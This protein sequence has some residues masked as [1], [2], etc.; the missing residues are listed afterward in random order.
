MK[1]LLAS[2]LFLAAVSSVNAQKTS[3]PFPFGKWR[4]VFTFR[5]GVEVPVNFEIAGKTISDA[6]VFFLNAAERFDGGR[7]IKRNDSLF[8]SLDQFDNELAFKI[9]GQQL[10]GVLRKQ[11]G[12]GQ[13]IAVKADRGI[14]YRFKETGIKP[15]GDI[16]GTY[17]IIFGGKDSTVGL[18]TQEGNKLTAT[19]LTITGDS[20]YLQGVV[21]GNQ[22][23]LSSFIGSSPAYYRGSFNADGTVSG[24]QVGLRGARKFEGRS[25]EEARLPDLYS[26]TYLK[27][28]YKRFDFSLPDL[29]GHQV[30]LSDDKYKNKVV[31]IAITGSWCPNCMDETAFL[32]P[33]YKQNKQRG[34]EIVAIHYERKDDTAFAKKAISRYRQKFDVQYD[35]VFGGLADKQYVAN[36]LPSLNTFLSF[37]TTIFINK[38]GEV[39][40]IHTGYTGP[41]TG[42]FYTGFVRDFNKEVEGLLNE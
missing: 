11:D 16:S 14:A 2:A 10:V 8:I 41:A 30:S 22:F 32:S 7:L 36:S 1:N 40:K 18:F 17:D 13:P 34:V 12:S 28:G 42:R 20:R 6:K 35:Q 21:E 33:W 15:A 29:N 19:F 26:L 37:P 31:I 24:E 5:E 23:W 27:N 39:A 9:E 3:L 38:K 4:A 25:N